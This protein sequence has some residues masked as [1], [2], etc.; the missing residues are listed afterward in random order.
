MER[1]RNTEK[2]NSD[3]VLD[4]FI[5][6]KNKKM[7]YEQ[8]ARKLMS[9]FLSTNLSI[10]QLDMQDELMSIYEDVKDARQFNETYIGHELSEASIPGMWGYMLGVRLGGNTVAREVSEKESALE[11]EAMRGFMKIIGYNEKKASGTFTSG[12]SIAVFTAVDVAIKKVKR[13]FEASHKQIE[14]PL[15]FLVNPYAHYSLHKAIDALGG[16][17]R[18]VEKV[19]VDA[20]GFKMD[21]NDLKEKVQKYISEG[22]IIA[23]IFAIAGET[24][25]G[26]VDPLDE[27]QKVAE[28]YKIFTIADAAFGA[29]FRLSRKGD[30]FKGMEK[31]DA[32]I[33]DGHK[34]LYTPYSNGA[35]LFRDKHDHVLLNLGV[36]APYVKFESSEKKMLK[37]LS[38]KNSHF[39]LGEKRY[40]GSG[41]PGSILS[42]VAVL[43]TLGIE[44]IATVCD[45]DLDRIEHLHDR[46]NNSS[47]LMPI[48]KPDIN[49]QCFRIRP[50]LEREFKINSSQRTDIVERSRIDDLD[51]GVTGKDGYFFSSTDFDLPNYKGQIEGTSVWR[52]CIM[53]PRTTDKIID[54][55]ISELENSVLRRLQSSKK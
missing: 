34:M 21:V 39:S 30:L 44:G 48:H 37:S 6:P 47:V 14:K 45:R 46:L 36:K 19:E 18:M 7:H 22:R 52:S 23:G 31:F 33:I 8:F 10:N 9:S 50:E 26:L 38:Y 13:E 41:G 43:R 5:D 55:A 2:G 11:P 24:E 28:K 49:L 54:V 27:I 40:E 35:V 15:I 16:P 12:G 4:Y 42:T 51:N 53:N 29:P 32:T 1:D 17:N 3:W 20:P 25:T